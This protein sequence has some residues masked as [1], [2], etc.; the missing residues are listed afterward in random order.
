M[1]H[2]HPHLESVLRSA[3]VPVPTNETEE[4]TVQGQRGILLNRS[5]ILN[6]NGPV[7]I[8]NYRINDDPR[9][10]VITKLSCQPI[11]YH[12]DIQVRYLR[13]PTPAPAG[14]IIIRYRMCFIS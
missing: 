14:D 8:S 2:S 10:E 13:P 1:A 4:A 11:E 3:N 6:W 12:Q 9:P 5:E 7:P